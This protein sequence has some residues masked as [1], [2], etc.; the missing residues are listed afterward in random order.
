MRRAIIGVA[1]VLVAALVVLIA[2]WIIIGPSLATLRDLVIVAIG[3][4]LFLLLFS[5]VGV[6]VALAALIGLVREKLPP[7]M[8]QATGT[9]GSVLGTVASVRSRTEFAAERV[10][11]PLIK[12]SAAAAGARAAVQTLL[13]RNNGKR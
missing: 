2:I 10:T 8:D 6:A 9:A 13:R 11:S 3:V 12:A 4:A 7:L 5:L 1:A